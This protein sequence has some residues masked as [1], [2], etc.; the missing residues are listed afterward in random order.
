MLLKKV[1]LCL[2]AI[3]LFGCSAEVDDALDGDPY[4][5]DDKVSISLAEFEKIQNGMTYEEVVEIIGGECTMSA[6]TGEKNSQFYTVS[7][8]CNG[9]G[10]TGANAQ[11][12]FQGGKLSMKAQFGL[13]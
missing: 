12:M 1:V 3:V 4:P 13:K 7:Y 10:T 5:N 6:E 9:D 2:L 11:L 8:G